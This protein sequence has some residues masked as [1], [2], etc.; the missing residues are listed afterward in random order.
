[1][2]FLLSYTEFLKETVDLSKPPAEPG[3]SVN[4][5]DETIEVLRKKLLDHFFE[6]VENL[7]D[8]TKSK[9]NK[10]VSTYIYAV[11][12]RLKIDEDIVNLLAE[13]IG[14]DP[15]DVREDLTKLT[16]EYYDGEK[17]VIS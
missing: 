4:Y 5:A 11:D 1:M 16:N 9:I 3:L 6:K 13:T 2:S 10:C 17:N 7:T 8:E 12:K 14:K 15:S